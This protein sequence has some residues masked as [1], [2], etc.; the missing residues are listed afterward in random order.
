MTDEPWNR[1]AGKFAQP[2]TALPE[3]D[4]SPPSD[5]LRAEEVARYRGI[6]PLVTEGDLESI[7]TEEMAG[8]VAPAISDSHWQLRLLVERIERLDG[9]IADLRA[10]RKDVRGEAKANGFDLKALDEVLRRRRMDPA[11]RDELDAL[12]GTYEAALG[13]GRPGVI[14]CGDLSLMRALPAPAAALSRDR[15]ALA[16]ADAWA[17]GL[18]R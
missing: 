4:A 2:S 12:I 18:G 7:E 10:D 14:D 13:M 16:E 9:E 8:E 5:Q 15:K 3:A 11:S 6:E 17:E 1:N